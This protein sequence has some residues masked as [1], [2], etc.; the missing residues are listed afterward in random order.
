MAPR[1]REYG[2][3]TAKSSNDRP[4]AARPA[5]EL[6]TQKTVRGRRQWVMTA[7]LSS[8]SPR[9]AGIGLFAARHL[10]RTMG[11]ELSVEP[12]EPYGTQ[13]VLRL[14]FVGPSG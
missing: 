4:P 12:R 9:G 2:H 10:A 13:F 3:S 5:G 1:G 11:G 14:G 6:I 8:T 7:P